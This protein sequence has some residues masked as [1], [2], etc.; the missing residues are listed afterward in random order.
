MKTPT[1][2]RLIALLGYVS[3]LGAVPALAQ[4]GPI[5]PVLVLPDGKLEVTH[6]RPSFP[7]DYSIPVDVYVTAAGTVS[8]AVVSSTSG[9]VAADGVAASYMRERKFLPALDA[10]SKPVDSVVKVNVNMF[11][12]GTKKVVRVT[13]KPP[14]VDGETLR[15]R[16]L[17]CA[18][19]LWEVNRIKSEAG[20]K[21]FSME[22]M[23]FMSAHMYVAQ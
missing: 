10:N 16:K 22:V 6:D 5:Q 15:V 23:P 19:F 21:D 18:D 20:I 17:M 3:L 9:N 1:V 4:V 7:D 14:S 11:K 12:R 13:L 2:R 8:S